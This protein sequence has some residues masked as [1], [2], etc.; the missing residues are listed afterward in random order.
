MES[1][2][3]GFFAKDPARTKH[4][5][6]PPLLQR[7]TISKKTPVEIDLPEFLIRVPNL[8]SY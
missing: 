5:L 4:L 2:Y 1:I 8:L 7:G 6:Q 3:A